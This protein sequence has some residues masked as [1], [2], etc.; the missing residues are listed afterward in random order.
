MYMKLTSP[1]FEDGETIPEKFGY[2]GENVN[3]ELAIEEVPDEAEALALLMEDPDAQEAA[4]KVWLHWLVWNIPVDQET[5]EEDSSPGVEGETDFRE[6]E[7][8]G[9][10]PPDGEHELVFRLYALSEE[11]ELGRGEDEESFKNAVEDKVIAST[12]LKAKYP[13]EHITM[14]Q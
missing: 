2:M 6:T 14:D 8:N 1:E 11:L 9:P 4:G 13:H 10:N 7:Y 12:E 5:I 3:P